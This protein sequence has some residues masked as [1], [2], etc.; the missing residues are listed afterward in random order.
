VRLESYDTERYH[1]RSLICEALGHDDL[2]DLHM[3][4]EYDKPFTMENNSDTVPHNK[5]YSKIRDGWTDFEQLYDKF[6]RE[7]I[8]P[9]YGSCNFVYQSLPTFRVHLVGNWVVSEFH[10]DSQTGYNHPE[11][12]INIQ[13]AITDIFDTNATWCESVPGL[14]D[15][16]PMELEHN[17]FMIF[18]GSKCRHGNMIN[19]TSDTRVS[20]DFRILPLEKYEP[21][22]SK[23][24][25]TRKMRFIVGEYY[26]E[27]K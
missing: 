27:L 15:Y 2:E 19:E 17:E 10:C 24:S 7:V 18:N 25:G 8:V 26:K 14:G 6:V 11:G 9:I 23:T 1:F 4:Y 21:D 3:Y 22:M 5:F 16:T 13:V 12:E 20:F